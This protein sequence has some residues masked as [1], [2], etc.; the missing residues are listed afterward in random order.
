[1]TARVSST[2]KFLQIP[3]H[4]PAT[5][6][7]RHLV[8]TGEDVQQPYFSPED[9]EYTTGKENATDLN[10]VKDQVSTPNNDCLHSLDHYILIIVYRSLTSQVTNRDHPQ[11]TPVTSDSRPATG[12]FLLL[13]SSCRNR[14]NCISLNYTDKRP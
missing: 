1:M 11:R 3:E 7:E 12:S 10:T 6:T 9:F 13:Q 2:S 8:G 5:D 4:N 14:F